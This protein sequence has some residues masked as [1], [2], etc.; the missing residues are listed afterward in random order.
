MVTKE[1]KNLK[2][3]QKTSNNPVVNS[4]IENVA[5]VKTVKTKNKLKGGGNIEVDD[6]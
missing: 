4:M 2:L 3:P 6:E 5:T 1:D